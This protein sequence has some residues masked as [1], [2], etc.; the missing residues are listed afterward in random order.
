MQWSFWMV[1]F[2]MWYMDYV[3][4]GPKNKIIWLSNLSILSVADE[5]YPRNVSCP[6]HYISTFLILLRSYERYAPTYM[7]VLTYYEWCN[8]FSSSIVRILAN[9]RIYIQFQKSTKL[10]ALI[11]ILHIDNILSCIVSRCSHPYQVIAVLYASKYSY[12][13]LMEK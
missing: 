4:V 9:W 12:Y 6:L 1:D 11:V 8:L 7:C 2:K 3:H 13:H 5:D 10:G